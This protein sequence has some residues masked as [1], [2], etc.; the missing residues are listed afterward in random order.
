MGRTLTVFVLLCPIADKGSMSPVIA[1]GVKWRETNYA[2]MQGVESA[3]NALGG[4]VKAGCVDDA[5]RAVG[6][7]CKSYKNG[8][9]LL[10]RVILL[11]LR[12]VRT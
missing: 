10:A 1:N 11:L 4:L 12:L 9:M 5:T 6:N 2:L 3:Q 7:F 8:M